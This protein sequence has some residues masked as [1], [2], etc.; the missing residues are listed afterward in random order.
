MREDLA[1]GVSG[2][3]NNFRFQGGEFGMQ[4]LELVLG[5]LH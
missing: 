3:C 1:F 4:A 2:W 5:L